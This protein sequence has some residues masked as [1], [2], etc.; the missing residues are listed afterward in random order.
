[1]NNCNE[2]IGNNNL[3][4]TFY[5]LCIFGHRNVLTWINYLLETLVV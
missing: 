5:T 3:L 2:F 1:M 4:D